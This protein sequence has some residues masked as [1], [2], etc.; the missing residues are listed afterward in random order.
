M[1]QQASGL[2]PR[3]VKASASR[4]IAM[5]ALQKNRG[6]TLFINFVRVVFPEKSSRSH[7]AF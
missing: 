1:R 2:E 4:A 6:K 5:V 3:D 7:R